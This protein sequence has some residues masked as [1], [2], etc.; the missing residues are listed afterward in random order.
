MIKHQIS[1]R[2]LPKKILENFVTVKKRVVTFLVLRKN[3]RVVL[4]KIKV[5]WITCSNGKFSN[6]FMVKRS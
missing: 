4:F 6:T 5:P 2:K 1:R 3:D